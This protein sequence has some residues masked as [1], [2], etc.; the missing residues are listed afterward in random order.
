MAEFNKSLLQQLR[1]HLRDIGIDGL[2][3]GSGDAHQSEYVMSF[4]KRRQ[5]ISGFSGSAGTCL[6]LQ[7]RALLWTDG[8][9]FLQASNELTEEWT[10][11]KSGMPGVLELDQWVADNLGEGTV[12][13]V[14]AFLISSQQALLLSDLWKKKGVVLK[15]I[16]TN[17]V[18]TLW[19]ASGTRPSSS[20]NPI[21]IHPLK[22][23]GVAYE[24]KLLTVQDYVRKNNATAILITALDEIAWLLNIRGSD[25]DFNP[26]VMSYLLVTLTKSILFVD[27]IKVTPD[28]RNHLKA[29]LVEILPYEA[30]DDY[31]KN[32]AVNDDVVLADPAVV[33]WR[34]YLSLGKNVKAT[35]SPVTLPK[36]LKNAAEIEGM[37]QSHIRDGVA[38]TAFLCW[39]EN[40][41]R[42][43]E[44]SIITEYQVAEKI[45]E[46]RHKMPMHLYP[47]FETIAGYGPNGAIIHYKPKEES[48]NLL[49]KDALFLLDSGAQYLDGTTDVTR[50]EYLP[51]VS[52]SISTRLCCVAGLF[53]SEMLVIA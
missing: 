35:V 24:E 22:Y 51:D 47:S 14:D 40:H 23:A 19:N 25:I 48:S 41:V 52:T 26:V 34:L 15:A 29:N 30:V 10:L 43:S 11:M 31:M 53:A 46:F 36:S 13:G 4:D 49:K 33:N 39:L 44:S 2:I 17:P 18:D 50:L 38:L 3:V 42:S 9:Y 8:R 7:D 5:F 32:Y 45:E 21:I 20:T 28:V 16:D 37:R 6:I 27:S 12:I 1:D